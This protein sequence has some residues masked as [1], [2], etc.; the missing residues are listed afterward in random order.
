[1][2]LRALKLHEG[3]FCYRIKVSVAWHTNVVRTISFPVSLCTQLENSK[4]FL[5]VGMTLPCIFKLK[6]I[7]SDSNNILLWYEPQDIINKKISFP[8][9]QLIPI[10]RFL[11]MHDYVC[12]IAPTKSRIQDFLWKLFSFNTKMISKCT[13]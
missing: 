11:V 13:S 5:F 7:F 10:L 4:C 8:K 3:A 12:F 6:G 1:M 2:A 9:F